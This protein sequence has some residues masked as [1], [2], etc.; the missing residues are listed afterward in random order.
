VELLKTVQKLQQAWDRKPPKPAKEAFYY[1][2]QAFL[3]HHLSFHFPSNLVIN[4]FDGMALRYY[5]FFFFFSFSYT[6]LS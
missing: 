4:K 6:F 1:A 2:L 5:F 3:N